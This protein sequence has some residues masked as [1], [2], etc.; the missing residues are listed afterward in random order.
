MLNNH[1][2]WVHLLLW[3]AGNDDHS[4][5]WV[6][7]AATSAF[8]KA[9][10]NSSP[11]PD[12]R[13]V[14]SARAREAFK[15][16]AK[17]QWQ[18]GFC[19]YSIRTVNAIGFGLPSLPWC[20]GKY[21]P[22]EWNRSRRFFFRPLDTPSLEAHASLSCSVARTKIYPWAPAL[23]AANSAFFGDLYSS[24]CICQCPGFD[25]LPFGNWHRQFRNCM[26]HNKVHSLSKYRSATA[27]LTSWAQA[28]KRWA[29]FNS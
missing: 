19:D 7:S 20:R 22:F 10:L 6:W 1:Q 12:V 8:F 16:S 25:D 14:A 21:L 18:A 2:F 17:E 11:G 13:R 29:S 23:V 15:T 24:K 26:V 3:N 28:T 5:P 4:A 27:D 9:A